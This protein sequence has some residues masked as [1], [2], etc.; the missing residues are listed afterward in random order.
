MFA[1]ILS[2]SGR[3]VKICYEWLLA[4]LLCYYVRSLNRRGRTG[5]RIKSGTTITMKRCLE[6]CTND[7]SE[8]RTIN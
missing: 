7:N 6:H 1:A 5:F 3:V 8:Q 4:S 2:P